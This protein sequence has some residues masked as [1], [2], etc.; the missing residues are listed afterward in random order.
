MWGQKAAR[1]SRVVPAAPVRPTPGGKIDAG[2]E[3]PSKAAAGEKDEGEGEDVGVEAE[4]DEEP[5]VPEESTHGASEENS[6]DVGPEEEVNDE[7]AM[8]AE[9]SP[10][11]MEEHIVAQGSSTEGDGLH[12]SSATDEEL[13]KVETKLGAL[14]KNSVQ[15]TNMAGDEFDIPFTPQDEATGEELIKSVNTTFD[16]LEKD[17]AQH[18][19]VA[20]DGLDVLMIPSEAAI[21]KEPI[22]SV[23]IT[24]EEGAADQC[25]NVAGDG[26]DAS[27]ISHDAV[28]EPIH[29]V[30]TTLDELEKDV[31]S[32]QSKMAGGGLDA[33]ASFND[34]KSLVKKGDTSSATEGNSIM[35][36]TPNATTP[37]GSLLSCVYPPSSSTP[38]DAIQTRGLVIEDI[39]KPAK[40]GWFVTKNQLE[41]QAMAQHILNLS[42][43]LT[44]AKDA[45]QLMQEQLN[46]EIELL[47]ANLLESK[48]DN[49]RQKSENE[50]LQ[51]ERE[52]VQAEK[53]LMQKELF[54]I[55]ELSGITTKSDEISAAKNPMQH[56]LDSAEKLKKVADWDSVNEDQ[57]QWNA[58]LL[59]L[60]N[61]LVDAIT[62]RD[63][64]LGEICELLEE[65]DTMQKDLSDMKKSKQQ[66]TK[67]LQNRVAEI[68]AENN[69]MRKEIY[70][71]ATMKDEVSSKYHSVQQ[72]LM[73][74][75]NK[76]AEITAAK[77]AEVEALQKELRIGRKSIV[78][79]KFEMDEVL[80]AKESKQQEIETLQ[81]RVVQITADNKKEV[82]SLRKKLE[83][84]KAKGDEISAIK[85]SMQQK[86]Q[87]LRSEMAEI[88]TTKD[89]DIENLQKELKSVGSSLV[90][91]TN[92][93]D[94][95]TEENFALQDQIENLQN[96]VADI[97]AAKESEG[98]D[99]RQKLESVRDDVKS[100]QNRIEIAD[101]SIEKLSAQLNS[102]RAESE[103]V[104][105]DMAARFDEVKS[106]KESQK[107][108]M[109]Q[110]IDSLST[111]IEHATKKS[112]ALSIEL[113]DAAKAAS[114]V[115]VQLNTEIKLLKK[116][117]LDLKEDSAAK[118]SQVE[119]LQKEIETLQTSL[120]ETTTNRDKLQKDMNEVLVVKESKQQEI[121]TAKDADVEIEGRNLPQELAS[122]QDDEGANSIEID[123]AST[124]TQS[125][126]VEG[127]TEESNLD[128]AED[129]TTTTITY[130]A[131]TAGT[132]VSGE[133]KTQKK[134]KNRK[135]KNEN[136]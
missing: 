92:M 10:T 88:T 19:K 81:N 42:T 54:L 37:W 62:N 65:K 56:K 80:L 102:E 8:P 11:A 115:Q 127:S 32:L 110:R 84:A 34:D 129:L 122:V 136:Q 78:D 135:K 64:L 36:L 85:E 69:S 79:M 44:D 55:V 109:M 91:A 15:S 24:L 96:D 30:D 95:M 118:S 20:G 3:T 77:L 39:A 70:E 90:A 6:D 104:Q 53:D 103:S 130:A 22:E 21:G 76:V 74:L 1:I 71:I 111:E 27:L 113:S 18:S 72:E 128:A 26:L 45:A 61:A 93:G 57:I 14:E 134:K 132:T 117:L 106:E 83:T 2:E 87:A 41:K 46:V 101:N 89:A 107:L 48:Q 35:D 97:T 58:Q 67:T 25:S 86:N 51:K 126:S 40:K 12:V 121:T 52:S 16:A 114:E 7:P 66:E 59:N 131:A 50:R 119:G 124:P 123:P 82:E 75:Q 38:G 63:K 108:E 28:I 60:R 116:D 17:G 94:M 99:L 105:K 31:P 29:S 47:K 5:T 4:I 13:I 23:D 125:T 73:S 33:S 100:Y 68:T 98:K 120:L 9:T 112:A 43:E 133:Q 49:A